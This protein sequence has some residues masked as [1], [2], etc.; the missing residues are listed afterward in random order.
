MRGLLFVC[1]SLSGCFDPKSPAQ[2]L[3]VKPAPEPS[4][5]ERTPVKPTNFQASV[6]GQTVSLRWD[7]IAGAQKYH[8]Q[9]ASAS[10]PHVLLGKASITTPSLRVP[11]LDEGRYIFQVA[12]ETA[13]GPGPMES[14][15]ATVAP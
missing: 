8:M 14:L 12:Q 2:D 10:A 13:R 3:A 1:L 6:Q 4:I 7:A 11:D 9:W 15:E 5:H